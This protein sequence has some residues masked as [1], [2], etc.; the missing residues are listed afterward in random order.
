MINNYIS[1][2]NEGFDMSGMSDIDWTDTMAD[3][4]DRRSAIEE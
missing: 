2:I 4:D 1:C 3:M